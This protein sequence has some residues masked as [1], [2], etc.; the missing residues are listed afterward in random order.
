MDAKK[1]TW[2]FFAFTA[3]A[4]LSS[5]APAKTSSSVFPDNKGTS[6]N[7]SKQASE[8][9]FIVQWED[10]RFTVESEQSA[11]S[12]RKGFVEKNLAQIK[13]VDRDVRIQADTDT[14]VQTHASDGLNWGPNLIQASALWKQGI[15]GSGIV[16]GVID[17]MV[18]V[19]HQQLR[20]N[21]YINKGEI[22]QNGIDD[23]GNG[24]IDDSMGIQVNKEPNDPSKNRHGSHVSG[25]IAADSAFGPV[26]G[27]APKA[28][29]LPAQF[30]AN[31]GGGS[32]GD[33]II[34]MKYAASRGAKI[35]NLSW[36][37]D[38][39]VEIPNLKDVIQQMSDQGII[40]VS[41]SGN[42]DQF[43]V[44]INVDVFPTY[45]S[46]YNI[47]NQINVAATTF[48]DYMIGFS[49]YGS[50][51]V[52]VGAPGVSIY[53]TTPGNK[54]ES[55]SGTSMAAPMTSGAAALIWSGV[56][57]ATAN[58]VKQ[59]L[60]K[61]VDIVPNRQIE[62]LSRGRINVLKAYTELK[63]IVGP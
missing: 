23:D 34:G 22:P 48:D 21:I 15:D 59:A 63:K 7:C 60:I 31:D 30:I 9:R 13:H 41:A 37:G 57:Q 53:S 27:V 42:G 35:L 47:L 46:A 25:I 36:G 39:C 52:H 32:I 54:V 44:G 24:Y 17:G 1:F 4:I 49:N 19:T 45:P 11:D 14:P 61:S 10:G 5:C 20:S 55:M 18:D 3:Y 50:R 28:K 29:I 40:I 43:G 51:T 2:V 33:A 6:M 38:P 58:Q 12:F 16:V 56:P 8:N 62:V 26:Q